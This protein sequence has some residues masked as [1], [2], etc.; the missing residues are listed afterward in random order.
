M[1]AKLQ[2]PFPQLVF[3]TP[4]KNLK[5]CNKQNYLYMSWCFLFQALCLILGSEHLYWVQKLVLNIL[6]SFWFPSN[7]RSA[8]L[9]LPPAFPGSRWIQRGTVAT[10]SAQS[11]RPTVLSRWARCAAVRCPGTLCCDAYTST[12]LSSSNKMQRNCLGLKVTGCVRIWDSFWTKDTQ[13][14][15]NPTATLKRLEQKQNTVPASCTQCHLRGG[16]AA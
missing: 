11:P 4:V 10:V 9:P 3:L 12:P 2:N 6:G 15:K 5:L 1:S 16:Q 7:T 13:R 14:P 8:S